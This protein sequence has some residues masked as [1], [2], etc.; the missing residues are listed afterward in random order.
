MA[1]KIYS[2]VGPSASSTGPKTAVTVVATIAIRPMVNEFE[3]GSSTTPADV[4]AVIV[5]ARFTAAGTAGSSPTPNPLDPADVA[6]V[7]TGGITHSAEPTYAATHLMDLPI[8]QRA[9][10]RWVAQDGREF[11]APATA[12]NGIGIQMNT[13]GTALVLNASMLFR[14]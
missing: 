12:A 1:S 4:A 14:E 7:S 3:L 5:V 13:A 2:I 6:S 9:T 10:F 8:N 11:I